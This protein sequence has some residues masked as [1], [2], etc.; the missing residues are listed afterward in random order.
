MEKHRWEESEK[1]R[2]EERRSEKRKSQKKED[3]G[4]RKGRKVAKHCVFPMIC[5]SGGSKSRLAQAAGAEPPGQM[6]DEKLHAVVARSRFAS[7]NVQNTSASEHFWK[8]RCR[9]KCTPLWRKAH[10]Q[11]KKPETPGSDHFLTFRCRRSAWQAQGILRVAKSEQ[12][13]RVLC[14]FTISKNDGR[15]GTFAEDLARCMS[16]GRRSAR[17]MFIRDVKRSGR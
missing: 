3:A 17:D 15:R 5:G 4:A 16:P 2:A 9:K 1:R 7:Q 6:R 13:V 14:H 12:N 10:L 11:V 8:L